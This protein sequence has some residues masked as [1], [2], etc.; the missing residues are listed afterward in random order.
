M[1]LQK[2]R[3]EG[4]L[5]PT[6]E[7]ILEWLQPKEQTP[8]STHFKVAP[9]GLRQWMRLLTLDLSAPE[10]E[11]QHRP[12]LLEDTQ[13]MQV[14][15]QDERQLDFVYVAKTQVAPAVGGKT[16]TRREK[17]PVLRASKSC[18]LHQ[19]NRAQEMVT[20]LQQD[21]KAHTAVCEILS[22]VVTQARLGRG[23]SKVLLNCL[24]YFIRKHHSGALSTLAN[25]IKSP[26]TYAHS[27]DVG[28]IFYDVFHKTLPARLG[29]SP[30]RDAKQ[31]LLGGFLHDIGKAKV[32]LEILESQ[33]KFASDGY[34][35]GLIR[36]HPEY[37]AEILTKM[38]QPDCVIA[39]AWKHHVRMVNTAAN[40]YPAGIRMEELS[41]D[42]KLLSVIDVYQA[43]VG[44][45]SYKKT[46][47]P[48]QAV[49]YLQNLAGTDLDPHAC[50]QFIAAMGL[51]PAGSLVK[52]NTGDAAFV[53]ETHES[54]PNQPLV[55]VVQDEAGHPLSQN[56]VLDLTKVEHVKIVNDLDPQTTLGAPAYEVF[57]NMNLYQT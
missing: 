15:P 41:W 4:M 27:I 43:L 28:L 21:H 57:S 38:E 13:Q 7:W 37:G 49:K 51:Y 1:K 30:F 52:L 6:W 39:L 2:I 9:T 3:K 33:E 44:A 10:D 18:S 25:L 29:E 32:P 40:S 5:R 54:Q 36:K 22:E 23:S 8:R 55:A 19:L 26:Q 35:M 11:P 14:E 53:L 46:W 24:H 42:V 45:R 34:E 17:Q 56:P 47:T 20:H 48:H 12:R 31:P 50:Q 16:K